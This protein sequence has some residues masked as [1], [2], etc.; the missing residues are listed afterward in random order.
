MTDTL[1]EFPHCS[2]PSRWGRVSSGS[3]WRTRGRDSRA[4]S[5]PL[6]RLGP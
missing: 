6:R 4:A 5:A 1:L 2:R 3:G